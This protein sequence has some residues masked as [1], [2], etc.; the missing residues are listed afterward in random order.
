MRKRHLVATAL[1]T[2]AFTSRVQAQGALSLE[3]LGYPTGQ[4]SARA[5]GTGGGVGDFDALSLVAPAALAGVGSSALFFQYS[6]EFRKVT[7]SSGSASTTTARFPLVAGVLPMGQ[8]W[9]LGLSSSTF[10]D[11]SLETS[12]QRVQVVG[13]PTDTVT[14]TERNK[15]LG[16]I[17]DVRLALA[18]STNPIFRIGVGAHVFS[19]S[20]RITFSQLFPDSARYTSTSQNGR[21][22]YAGFA[23][24]LGLEFHPSRA[25]GFSINGRKGGD[26]RA[27]SGDTAIGSARIPDHYSASVT[28]EGIPG[29]VI[30]ARVAHDAW[31][32][33][34]NLSSSGIQAFDGWDTGVGIEASGPRILQRIITVRAGARFRT[35]PFGYPAPCAPPIPTGSSCTNPERVSETSFAAGLGVPLTRERAS[36]DLSLQRASRSAADIKERGF[37]LSIGLRVSP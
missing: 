20:N 14:L 17:N 22:S 11:R 7:T 31:S 37:I 29:A 8:D 23:A 5:E 13:T 36:L 27:E 6:P 9:T 16:A 26:L 34:T 12:L 21:I 33:L 1:F 25:I 28:F 24:S 35:L 18:W 4:L 30:S 15:V 3:G 19:G 2:L 32:S 10:L